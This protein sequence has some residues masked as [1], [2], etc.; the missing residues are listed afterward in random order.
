MIK[1]IPLYP[2]LN[3]VVL[4]T[5][6][7]TLTIYVYLFSLVFTSGFV[8]LLFY[9]PNIQVAWDSLAYVYKLKSGKATWMLEIHSLCVE[10]FL[11]YLIVTS[12][13]LYNRPWKDY[14]RVKLVLL[15][16]I[17]RI[18]LIFSGYSLKI[19]E[20]SEGSKLF[21][22]N[23][24]SN[25]TFYKNL[26]QF[27]FSRKG[28]GGGV[29][30]RWVT[31]HLVLSLLLM[32]LRI[33]LVSAIVRIRLRGLSSIEK[34]NKTLKRK[35]RIRSHIFKFYLLIYITLFSYLL[36]YWGSHL[37]DVDF[38]KPINGKMSK[39]YKVM[40]IWFLYYVYRVDK[41]MET[42]WKHALYLNIRLVL[43]S[44]YS[45]TCYI[46]VSKWNTLLVLSSILTCFSICLVTNSSAFPIL[47]VYFTISI[48][49]F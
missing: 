28:I 6:S 10:L 7:V 2:N 14:C 9:L 8:L 37:K 49:N 45:F 40:P 36:A 13:W 11:L 29:V 41:A 39:A 23:L 15:L 48:L 47:W 20:L 33:F 35:L 34:L 17:V 44:F 19:C 1:L 4:S 42:N 25:F 32:I 31:I 21:L 16:N 30:S 5:Y 3:S 18:I 26:H 43:I 46:D 38:S 12:I 27:L 24:L 22:S